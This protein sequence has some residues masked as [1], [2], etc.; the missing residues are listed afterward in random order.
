MAIVGHLSAAG[1]FFFL[2]KLR[3]Q[4]IEASEELNQIDPLTDNRFAWR[5]ISN[6]LPIGDF[7]TMVWL[8][9][10][11]SKPSIFDIDAQ[12]YCMPVLRED[13]YLT[14]LLL[15]AQDGE[16]GMRYQR[17]GLTK[18]PSFREDLMHNLTTPPGRNEIE[19]GEYYDGSDRKL[20]GESTICIV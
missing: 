5:L 15:Q 4:Q 10:P 1:G 19:T 20:G 16:Y 14:C 6:K 17:V 18:V 13:R 8:D 3:R 7:Y 2:S 9:S 11:A 12:V